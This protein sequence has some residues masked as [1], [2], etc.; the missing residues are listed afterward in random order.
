MTSLREVLNFVSMLGV[1]ILYLSLKTIIRRWLL[2]ALSL[3]RHLMMNPWARFETR[4]GCYYF[5]VW[6]KC[7]SMLCVSGRLLGPKVGNSIKCLSQGHSDALPHR[8]SSQGLATFDYLPGTPTNWATPAPL[9]TEL[10]RCLYQLSCAV[11]VAHEAFFLISYNMFIL[12]PCSIWFFEVIL[13]F[14]KLVK[15]NANLVLP[16]FRQNKSTPNCMIKIIFDF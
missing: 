9:P 3:I 14:L 8:E 4:R 10:R 13:I 16:P 7:C 5:F 11:V 1:S 2:H 6:T 12:L 15:Y